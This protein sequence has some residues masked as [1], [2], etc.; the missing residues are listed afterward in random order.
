MS[1][2]KHFKA[3]MAPDIIPN[4]KA[5]VIGFYGLFLGALVYASLRP[6]EHIY[7]IRFFNLEQLS[8]EIHS[9]IIKSIGY[10]LPA[11]LHVFSFCLITASFFKFKKNIYLIIC[12]GWFAVDALFEL[13]QKYKDVSTQMIPNFFAHL[14]FLEG[15][16]NYFR[17]GTFDYFDLIAYALGALT[18]FCYLITARG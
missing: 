8:F 11:F 18:A 5:L 13:G 2:I 15:T 14:P 7:F 1:D 17:L 12:C 4:K 9:N 16:N 3:K 6:P 10:R